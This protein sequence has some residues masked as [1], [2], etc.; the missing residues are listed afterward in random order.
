MFDP[1]AY[2]QDLHGKLKALKTKYK[3][4]MVS[5]TD[6]LEGVLQNS[7]H[8]K[9]FFAIDDSEDG[10]TYRG[11]GG[12]YFER[13]QYSVFILGKATYGDMTKR[14]EVMN[15]ARSIYRSL[16]SR[17]IKDKNIIPVVNT[18]QIRFNE[19]PPA[20]ATGC[21]GLYFHFTVE[22]AV[23]LKYNAADWES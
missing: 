8:E 17:I 18:E 5:G 15:E 1:V 14:A 22:N 4:T 21:S 16:V 12:G 19:V 6:A 7:R 23:D 3:F 20:F 13:R 2:M 10:I 11:A 9:Y